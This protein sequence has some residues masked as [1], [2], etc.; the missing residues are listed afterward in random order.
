MRNM[1][2]AVC[3]CERVHMHV[4]MYVYVHMPVW[5]YVCTCR[6][7]WAKEVYH[8]V[9]DFFCIDMSEHLRRIHY[10]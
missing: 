1:Y 7:V 9:R 3:V 5:A 8:S 4:Y 10:I 2:W 6:Q